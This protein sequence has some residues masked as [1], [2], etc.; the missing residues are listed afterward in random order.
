[1]KIEGTSSGQGLPDFKHG[2]GFSDGTLN[3]RISWEIEWIQSAK[4]IICEIFKSSFKNQTV[5]LLE[6]ETIGEEMGF[7]RNTNQVIQ[8]HVAHLT[9][10]N[11]WKMRGGKI[12]TVTILSPFR[13]ISYLFFSLVLK[14]TAFVKAEIAVDNKM[15]TGVP[16]SYATK[17]DVT[18]CVPCSLTLEMLHFLSIF[19]SSSIVFTAEL[20]NVFPLYFV[21]YSNWFRFSYL[22]QSM[23]DKTST[24]YLLVLRFVLQFVDVSR[25][26]ILRDKKHTVSLLVY[27]VVLSYFSSEITVPLHVALY[28][29]NVDLNFLWN[30]K[31]DVFPLVPKCMLSTNR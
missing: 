26:S 12:V 30:F 9:L 13:K 1:M 3:G 8:V 29:W 20:L 25:Y 23:F 7:R 15:F 19:S 31:C 11:I 17:L 27:G 24:L 10:A 5:K 2:A 18:Y 14:R 28:T 22:Y 16:C 6:K 4:W 21:L